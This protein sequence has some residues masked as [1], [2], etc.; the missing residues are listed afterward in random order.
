[1]SERY[2]EIK[3]HPCPACGGMLFVGEGGYITCSWHQCPSPDYA[4][5]LASELQ[6]VTPSL[7]QTEEEWKQCIG[8]SLKRANVSFTY[9]LLGVDEWGCGWVMN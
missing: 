3:G 2:P 8:R 6:R 5:I 9:K 7:P 4:I 1:M